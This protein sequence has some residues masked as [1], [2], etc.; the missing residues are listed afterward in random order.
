MQGH[1]INLDV[2]SVYHNILWKKS[3]KEIV[4]VAIDV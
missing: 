3:E 2:D 4:W 1:C